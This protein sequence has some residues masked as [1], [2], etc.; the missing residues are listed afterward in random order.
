MTKLIRGLHNIAS[1]HQGGVVT[2]G[3]FDGVHLGHQRLL[4][5]LVSKAK[6]YGMS[7]TVMTFDPQPL[8]FFNR[9]QVTV[10]RLTNLREK[11]YHLADC[12]VDQVLVLSFDE[13]L[14]A[15]TAHDFVQKILYERLQAKHVLVGE[16]FRFGSQRLGDCSLLQKLG[17]ECHFTCEMM[18]MQQI[19][20][21]RVSSTRLRQALAKFDSAQV[22]KLLGHAY[23]MMGRVMYGAQ[24]GRQWGFPTAN[25]YLQRLLTPVQGVYVVRVHGVANQAWPGVANVGVRPTVDGTRCLLEVHL[26]DFD[27]DIYR[28]Y[29]EVEFCGKLR[30]EKRFADIGLLRE[31]IAEDVRQAREYF[32]SGNKNER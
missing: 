11:F 5:H 25:I 6:V 10:P 12:G 2:I 31:Q 8:E 21:E 23:S 13:S 3:N 9:S 29:V 18:P 24:R 26:L 4:A 27:R 32:D 15:L 30:D 17:R 20:N 7:S 22:K 19:D 28:Q 16:D 14:A 1:Q